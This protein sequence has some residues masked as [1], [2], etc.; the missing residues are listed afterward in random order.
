MNLRLVTHAALSWAL[1]DEGAD[2]LVRGLVPAITVSPIEGG[3]MA[4]LR[5]TT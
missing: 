3:V 1:S 5:W 4:A 2:P